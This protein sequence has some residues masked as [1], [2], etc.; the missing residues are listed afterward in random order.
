MITY[1][2]G[3]DVGLDFYERTERASNDHNFQAIHIPY[4]TLHI[5]P[6]TSSFCERFRTSRCT[7]LCGNITIYV[8]LLTNCILL[9]V[10]NSTKTSACWAAAN[11]SMFSCAKPL[12]GDTHLR[13]TRSLRSLEKYSLTYYQSLLRQLFDKET[14]YFKFANVSDRL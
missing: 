10:D 6:A 3:C 9:S 8:K 7:V 11:I 1:R 14:S 2:V 4:I 12:A 5:F 13:I